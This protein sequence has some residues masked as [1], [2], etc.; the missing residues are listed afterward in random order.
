[1][2]GIVNF[3]YKW[4]E[5]YIEYLFGMDVSLIYDPKL[6]WK[7]LLQKNLKEFGDVEK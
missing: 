5:P 4:L 2:K 1:V 7:T 6:T 3:P